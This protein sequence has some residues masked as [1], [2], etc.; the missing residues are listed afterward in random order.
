MIRGDS[1]EYIELQKWCEQCSL[2]PAHPKR[3]MSCEIGI[4]EGL[5]S[6]IIMDTF[7]KRLKEKSN[8]EV[9]VHV[10]IDP[11]DDLK[12]QHYDNQP[13]YK[14]D[15]TNDMRDTM[16]QDFKFYR[17]EGVFKPY[18]MTDV[19]Y[20]YEEFWTEPYHFVHFDGPHMTADVLT[21]A[22]YFANRSI[23][24]TRFVFDDYTKYGM[25]QV[26]F[27]LTYFGFKTI[28]AAENKICLEKQT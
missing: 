20:M 6:K 19:K 9:Y 23:E 26:A 28:E 10:G 12:Y 7:M 24:G 5:G 18:I 17:K 13:A 14:A 8:S 11:Y 4:R 25:D 15:Y 21:Q 27:T 22:I 3:I 1:V 16:L 2:L